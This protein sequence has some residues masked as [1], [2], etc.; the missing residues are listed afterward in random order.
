MFEVRVDADDL[1]E[2]LRQLGQ[3]LD[4]EMGDAMGTSLQ[5]VAASAKGSTAFQDRSGQLRNSIQADPPPCGSFLRGDLAGTVSA[6]APHALVIE[7]GSGQHGRK[8]APYRIR[9]RQ[10]RA[11]R[12]PVEGGFIFRREIWHPGVAPRLYLASA[13]EQE[14]SEIE[15][16]F[17]DH[18]ELAL[19]RAGF[20]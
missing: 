18:V 16:I 5:L 7:E 4:R 8:G 1:V 3:E 2:G 12:I 6:G 20:G 17:G 19:A 10:R 15:R 13:L 14:L 11:L 9:P